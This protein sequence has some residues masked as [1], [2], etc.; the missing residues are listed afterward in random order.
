LPGRF[1]LGCP[2][3]VWLERTDVPLFVSDHRL[4]RGRLPRAAGPW[5]LDSGGFTE[6]QTRGRWTVTPEQYA[7]RVRQYRD[8]VK[9]LLW[10]APQDWMCEPAIIRGGTFG[11]T[12]FVGTGLS[13]PEHQQRT[14]ANL[15]DL[16]RIAPD[17]P[18]VPVLQGYTLADYLRCIDLYADANVDLVAEPLLGLGSVCRRQ[19]TSEIGEIVTA[20]RE[21][22][23]TRLHGFGVKAQG[24]ELYGHLLTSADS[25]AWS[26]RARR[27]RIRLPGHTHRNCASCL[28]WALTWRAALLGESGVSVVT[29]PAP[30]PV[31]ATARVRPGACSCGA[32][33][34]PRA[35][36]R[37]AS[38]CS[39]ACRQRGYRARRRAAA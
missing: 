19:A 24:L 39:A 32:P 8:Q 7:A 15:L 23:L 31:G 37:P 2:E 27:E 5:A 35:T 16:R 28:E 1:F 9:G 4:S 10:C 30:V 14:V 6:L 11:T 36:G 38:Y 21:A 3:P 29:E 13:V 18:W 34:T 25:Q 12:K 33:L 26:F 17:L 22:G 20:V